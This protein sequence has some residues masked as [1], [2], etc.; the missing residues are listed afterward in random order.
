MIFEQVGI[1]GC[2]L[3]G[4][5]FAQAIKKAGIAKHIIGYSKSPTGTQEA[6]A[7]GILNETAPSAMQAASGSDLILLAVPVGSMA[8]IFSDITPLISSG[9]L[10]MDVGSTKQNVVAAAREHLKK[11]I[12]CFVPAHPIAGKNLSGYQAADPDL[13]A[14]AKVILT[15]LDETSPRHLN[16]AILIWETIGAQVQLMQPEEHDQAL[17]AVSHLPH[18]LAFA[19]MKSV[20]DHAKSEHFLS[21][22]GDGFKDFTRIAASDP[23]LWRDVFMANKTEMLEQICAF[24]EILTQYEATLQANEHIKLLD[25]LQK[26]SQTRLEWQ[27]SRQSQT[28]PLSAETSLS[29][30]QEK[31]GVFTRLSAH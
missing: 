7:A 28:Q 31:D 14:H 5:S 19:Y 1:I 27:S 29:E 25:L 16:N 3:I 11:K 4:G 30:K 8:K 24:K 15:P 13:F 21:L 2:G 9:T 23:T 17:G 26:T 6:K 12:A 22:A 18:L 20:I 10:L